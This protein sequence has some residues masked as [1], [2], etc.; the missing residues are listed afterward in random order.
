MPYSNNLIKV[1]QLADALGAVGT[2]VSDVTETVVDAI[3]EV[4]ESVPTNLSDLVID[5]P[6]ST[7]YLDVN[8][9]LHISNIA[10]TPRSEE[11]S[12]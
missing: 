2:L 7:V 11:V 6:V 8:G 12:F 9:V 1:K 5:G 10:S 3:E 4:A